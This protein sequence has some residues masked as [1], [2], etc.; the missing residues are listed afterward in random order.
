MDELRHSYSRLCQESGAEPQESVLERLHELHSGRLDLATLSLTVDSCRA[1]GRLLPTAAGLE[2][3]V[4]SDCMLS[5]EGGRP[6][7]RTPGTQRSAGHQGLTAH[8]CGTLSVC[9][10]CARHCLPS[11]PGRCLS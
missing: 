8:V 3:L 10:S 6:W 2:E 7:A 9:L 4:L 1:L 5:E 11:C